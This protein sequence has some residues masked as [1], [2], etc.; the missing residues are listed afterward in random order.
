MIIKSKTVIAPNGES[1]PPMEHDGSRASYV[2]G[3][4][5]KNLHWQFQNALGVLVGREI[6]IYHTYVLHGDKVG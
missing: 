6:E 5:W 2:C 3:R 4:V 1:L